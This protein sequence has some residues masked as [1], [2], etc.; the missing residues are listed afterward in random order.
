VF[1]QPNTASNYSEPKAIVRIDE[2]A[3]GGAVEEYLYQKIK[4]LVP[5]G[6]GA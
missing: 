5:S 2:E 6:Q 3:T 4:V 1:F